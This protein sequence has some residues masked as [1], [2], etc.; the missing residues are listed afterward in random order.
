M[1]PYAALAV[2]WILVALFAGV[3]IG[4]LGVMSALVYWAWTA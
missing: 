3:V 1:S 4:I 2:E